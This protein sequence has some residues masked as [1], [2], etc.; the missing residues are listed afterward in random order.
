MTNA[1]AEMEAKSDRTMLSV[2]GQDAQPFLQ[3]LISNDMGLLAGRSALFAGLLT[4]QGKVQFE[5]FV[6]KDASGFVLDVTSSQADDLAK[7]LT[8]YRLRSKV[9]I[10]PG[11][12]VIAF[13]D[14]RLAELGERRTGV[15]APGY[16]AHRIALGVPEGGKDY[17]FGE[18]F[19]H[20]AMFDQLNGVSFTKGCYVG[21]EIVSRMQH[22]GTARSRFLIADADAPLPAMGTPVLAGAVPIGTMGS[23]VGNQGLALVRFDRLAD[24]YAAKAPVMAAGVP[25]RL[26]KPAYARFEVPTR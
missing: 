20:E 23:S 9:A 15:S 7:K 17:A 6:V 8:M 21:Q 10:E 16:D 11:K 19:P 22:R 24:A 13:A 14:P 2:G 26:A 1:D 25:L 3:G 4:P 12:A 5:F 18:L